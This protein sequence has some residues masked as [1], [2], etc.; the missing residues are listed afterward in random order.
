[1]KIFNHTEYNRGWRL[2]HPHYYR[3]WAKKNSTK[4]NAYSKKYRQKLRLDVLRHYSH[5][6][7][8]CACCGETILEFLTIDHVHGGGS[9]ARKGKFSSSIQLY[10]WLKRNHY[11]KGFQ[12]L[13]YNCNCGKSDKGVCPH[14]NL[15]SK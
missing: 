8:C 10:M 7:P 3:D 11:P 14:Q 12:V 4:V 9:H 15:N 13:C 5:G 6:N 1:M 2:K